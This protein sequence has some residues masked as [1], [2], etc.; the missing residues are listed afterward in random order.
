MCKLAAS[1]R[2][3][4]LLQHMCLGVSCRKDANAKFAN[5][6]PRSSVVNA[7][8]SVIAARSVKART[9]KQVTSL[10]VECEQTPI[11]ALRQH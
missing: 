7:V 8:K 3:C 5:I 4:F 11:A 2:V 10:L 6:Q 9:G 1:D